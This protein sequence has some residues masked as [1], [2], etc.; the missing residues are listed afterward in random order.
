MSQALI[1][2]A[3]VIYGIAVAGKLLNWNKLIAQSIGA[4][5]LNLNSLKRD[6]KLKV[7]FKTSAFH[8]SWALIALMLIKT[9]ML[10]IRSICTV[11]ERVP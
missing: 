1:L 11:A 3:K 2:S 8:D 7:L 4:A 9:V 5:R 6:V 10:I